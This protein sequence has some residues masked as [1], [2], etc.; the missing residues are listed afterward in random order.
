MKR[1][2]LPMLAVAVFGSAVFVTSNLL[3]DDSGA[4]PESAWNMDSPLNTPP[5]GFMALFNGKDLSG[6]KGLVSPHGR[7]PE[8]RLKLTPD[9]LAAEQV[10]ADKIMHRHWKVVDGI[11]TYDGKGENLCTAK[12]Y[13][14]FE[15]W[16]DWKIT[17][18]GDSGIYL[19]GSPQVQIWDPFNTSIAKVG[20][21][22]LY[23][24]QK[25]SPDPLV[26]DV[27][28]P[29]GEW[30]RFFI[31]MVGDKVTVYFNGKLVVDNEVLENYWNRK[32]PIY[33]KGQIELQNHSSPLFFKNIYLRELD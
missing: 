25:N 14:N 13:T 8:G 32:K 22:G 29:I 27:D 3:A 20:S 7:G 23:N 9:E 33:P 17:P 26:K 15:M 4:P 24:N 31:R 5:A 16:V 18:H 1:F 10:T 19:R 28:R 2:F 6:W 30:N 21:G 12:D 11:L